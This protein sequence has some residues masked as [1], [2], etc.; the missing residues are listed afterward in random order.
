MKNDSKESENEEKQSFFHKKCKKVL[1][2]FGSYKNL[3]YLCTT[4]GDENDAKVF[5]NGSL[6]Y[7]LYLR[8]KM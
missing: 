2:K 4:F 1:Q 7:W 8:E 5:E 6:I 3:P